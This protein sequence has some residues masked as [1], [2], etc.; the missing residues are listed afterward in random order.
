MRVFVILIYRSKSERPG[1]VNFW[2]KYQK[3]MNI[4]TG[5]RLSPNLL[6]EPFILLF[7]LSPNIILYIYIS[8]NAF[9]EAVLER[10]TRYSI[11]LMDGFFP[12]KMGSKTSREL[13]TAVQK[14]KSENIWAKFY[15]IIAIIAVRAR[16]RSLGYRTIVLLLHS[17]LCCCCCCKILISSFFGL[18]PDF[19]DPEGLT[20]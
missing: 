15:G 18:Q 12:S 1:W 13:R 2:W 8:G 9:P 4:Y 17:C 10:G 20:K 6:A 5:I 3:N 19:S 14:K 11:E 7:G 16:G